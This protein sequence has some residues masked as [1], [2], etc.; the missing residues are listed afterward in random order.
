MKTTVATIAVCVLVAVLAGA[1]RA[2]DGAIDEPP[3]CGS[4]EASLSAV[5][6]AG[7]EP[8][9]ALGPLEDVATPEGADAAEAGDLVRG[10]FDLAPNCRF[11]S[12]VLFY[13]ATD[14]ARLGQALVADASHCADFYISVPPLA[15]DKTVFRPLQSLL[16][17][18]LGP[19]VHPMA[20]IHLAGWTTWRTTNGKTWY[21]TGVEARRRAEAANYE[22]WALNELPSSIRRNDACRASTCS[23]SC[24][25]CTTARAAVDQHRGSCPPSASAAAD[26]STSGYHNTLKGSLPGSAVVVDQAGALRQCSSAQEV[27][28]EASRFSGIH[29]RADTRARS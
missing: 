4:G 6:C 22:E 26:L 15:A 19:T 14:W 13:A 18:E 24:V 23:S 27:Y 8:V 1:A 3:A 7:I 11:H 17:K 10:Q 20:E 2:D 29:A 9:P 21:E 16:L 12:E 28:A 5:E 25:A